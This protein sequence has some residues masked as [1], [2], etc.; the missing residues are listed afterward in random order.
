MRLDPVISVFLLTDCLFVSG[1]GLEYSTDWLLMASWGLRSV[2]PS[3]D[4]L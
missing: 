3:L 2:L 4:G 1:S